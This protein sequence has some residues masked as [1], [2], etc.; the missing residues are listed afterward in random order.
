MM[1][2]L[3]IFS[4]TLIY[5]TSHLAYADESELLSQQPKHLLS[6]QESINAMDADHDGIITV[7]EMRVF[8]E[9]QRGQGYK[10][11]QF[12]ALEKSSES[13]RCG[14]PFSQSLY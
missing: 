3:I 4:C 5:M 9:S 8:I 1:R 6:V 13:R 12:D 11:E 7:H 14:S 10:K 2:L